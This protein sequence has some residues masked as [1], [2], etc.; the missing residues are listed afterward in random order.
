MRKIGHHPSAAEIVEGWRFRRYRCG[1]VLGFSEQQRSWWIRANAPAVELTSLR[2]LC[3][4]LAT[5]GRYYRARAQVTPTNAASAESRTPVTAA[6][7]KSG[8]ASTAVAAKS[9]ASKPAVLVKS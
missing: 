2:R 4:A 1:F 7:L 6:L 8:A 3:D 5:E 9:L